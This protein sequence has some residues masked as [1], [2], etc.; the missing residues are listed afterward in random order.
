MAFVPASN[1]RHPY[2][3][4]EL[5]QVYQKNLTAGLC[6]SVFFQ[7]A[8]VLVMWNLVESPGENVRAR[9]AR[10]FKYEEVKLP[11]AMND[12]SFGLSF[13]PVL[14]AIPEAPA[15][16]RQV[17][18]RPTTS[19]KRPMV[20][21]QKRSG[22]GLYDLEPNA[23]EKI[24]AAEEKRLS[25][26]PGN[27]DVP[28]ERTGFPGGGNGSGNPRVRGGTPLASLSGDSPDGFDR[29]GVGSSRKISVGES[30]VGEIGDSESGD[31]VGFSVRWSQGRPRRKV[32]GSLPTYPAGVNVES[33]IV[34]LATVEPEGSIRS[35]QPARKGER[36]LEEAAMKEVAFWRFEPLPNSV[37]QLTQTCQITFLFRLQ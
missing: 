35:V 28:D 31:G 1:L 29:S 6:I 13:H 17:P 14:P 30:G 2:G 22:I 11:D 3:A 23:G 8:M 18:T 25:E 12:A 15:N 19:A 33:S 7:L 27:P 5:K 20:A 34:L 32:S 4:R 37:P 10:I 9:T 21:P 36:R 24:Q 26:V 16:L